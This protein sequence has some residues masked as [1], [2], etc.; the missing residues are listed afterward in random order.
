MRAGGQSRNIH[1]GRDATHRHHQGYRSLRDDHLIVVRDEGKDFGTDKAME[2]IL[3]CGHQEKLSEAE[4][5]GVFLTQLEKKLLQAGEVL[6]HY[7]EGYTF[8][9]F[10]KSVATRELPE[11]EHVVTLV[12]E[13]FPHGGLRNPR[14]RRDGLAVDGVKTVGGGQFSH[15]PQNSVVAAGVK[16]IEH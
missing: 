5:I 11:A 9:K 12:K 6:L 4:V 15:G 14:N 10:F 7:R 13:V 8:H 3:R 1:H 16:G 2:L